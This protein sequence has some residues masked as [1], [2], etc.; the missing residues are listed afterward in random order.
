MTEKRFQYNVNKNT[1]EQDGKFVAYMNSVD[2]VRI[3][4]KLNV[5]KKENEQL[6]IRFNE[7]REKSLKFCRNIDTLTIE[8]EQLKKRNNNQYN[9]LTELWQIIEEENWEKLIAMKKQLKE[10]EERLQKEWVCYE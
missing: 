7:E 4:N 9:Q 1:I 2:G 5:F 3:A 6:K 8:N 10:D